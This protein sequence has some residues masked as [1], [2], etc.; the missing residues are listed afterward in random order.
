MHKFIGGAVAVGVVSAPFATVALAE[1]F[2]Y[3]A[4][5]ASSSQVPAP[6]PFPVQ[7]LAETSG[8]ELSAASIGNTDGYTASD[9]LPPILREQLA[10]D[11]VDEYVTEYTRAGGLSVLMSTAVQAHMSPATALAATPNPDTNK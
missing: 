3:D 5:T 8:A 1:H 6:S 4:N 2:D 7:A 11:I 10:H 9:S